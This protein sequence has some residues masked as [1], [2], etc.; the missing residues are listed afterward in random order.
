MQKLN[1]SNVALLRGT[2]CLLAGGT[3][4][5]ELYGDMP[6]PS[7]GVFVARCHGIYDV[8]I[9]FGLPKF[10]GCLESAEL[11]IF[12]PQSD[13]SR[14]VLVCFSAAHM[15]GGF[16]S[17]PMSVGVSP[18]KDGYLGEFPKE[19]RETCHNLCEVVWQFMDR[20]RGSLSRG[21]PYPVPAGY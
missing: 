2:F 15:A 1:I 14:D 11:E 19:R 9:A 20:A 18:S 7:H 3:I 16:G 21:I 8:R 4:P 5:D 10:K 17:L 13:G 6:V 12:V